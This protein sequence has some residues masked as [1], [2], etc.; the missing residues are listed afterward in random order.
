MLVEGAKILAV[1]VGAADVP[2]DAEEMDFGDATIMPGLIDAHMHTFGMDSLALGGLMSARE[3]GRALRAA[4]ELGELLEAGFTSARCLGSSVGPDL[5]RAI[6]A[7]LIKGP[8]LVAAGE[9]ISTTAGTWGGKPAA[10]LPEGRACAVA[11]GPVEMRRRVR[12]RLQEGTDFIKL[13]LTKGRPNDINKA[14]GD[15]PFGQLLAMSDEELAAAVDEAHRNGFKVSVHAIGDQAVAQALDHGVDIIEHGY[16]ISEETRKRLAHAQT[17]VVTTLSQLHYHRMAFD[18]FGYSRQERVSFEAHWKAMLESF[19]T[20]LEAGVKFVLGTDLIG[21]PTHPLAFAAK[22]FELAVAG[23]MEATEALRAGTVLG[24][25]I[26]GI[27]TQT[28]QLT[29]GYDA[30]IVVVNG[31]AVD[32][33]RR[34]QQPICVIKSGQFALNRLG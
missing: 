4:S 9:F 16:A 26:L 10:L 24:A 23:G 11:D 19:R 32:D 7:G 17:P 33:V 1:G 31:S 6:A 28:G 25:E 21:R 15:D 2:P 18:E 13:G 8:R 30:D 29:Q 22:E 3:T 14:W 20:G 5:S 12:Q 27:S 34:L